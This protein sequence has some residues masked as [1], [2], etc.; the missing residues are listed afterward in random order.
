MSQLHAHH[1]RDGPLLQ[2]TRSTPIIFANLSD[3]VGSGFVESLPRP[4]GNVTGFATIAFQSATPFSSANAT[5]S[6]CAFA[7]A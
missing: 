3:P 5:P 2:Q 1:T 7:A 4:G 6:C